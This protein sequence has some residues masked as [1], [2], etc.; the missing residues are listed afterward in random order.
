VTTS[1]SFFSWAAER[2][3][4]RAALAGLVLAAVVGFGVYRFG[5]RPA[6]APSIV[7]LARALALSKYE[8]LSALPSGAPGLALEEGVGSVTYEENARGL[9]VAPGPGF[10][11]AEL[12]VSWTVEALRTR[13]PNAERL[14]RVS[15]SVRPVSPQSPALARLDFV[16]GA[17]R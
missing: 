7:E 16:L 9:L 8:E 14:R 13:A 10:D 11:P 4:G 17:P 2:G 1:P 3:A 12:R 5:R 6:P 15:I